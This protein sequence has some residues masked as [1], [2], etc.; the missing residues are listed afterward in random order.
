MELFGLMCSVPAAF[1]ASAIYFF[2]LRW[3]LRRLPWI[4]TVLVP[5]STLVLVG[6]AVEWILLGTIGTL[7]SRAAI[8][9][10]FFPLHT[11]LFFLS[12]PALANL[13]IVK[14]DPRERELWAEVAILCSV[15]AFPVVLIQYSVS[16][17]L[18]GI[19][20]TEGPYSAE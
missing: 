15:L 12:V 4:K 2:V 14:R 17:T 16:E 3:L 18:Y 13:L 10:L 20:G 6:L 5:G 11:V 7:R 19:N 8:G 1:A 9:P